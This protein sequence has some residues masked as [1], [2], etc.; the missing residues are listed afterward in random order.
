MPRAWRLVGSS[1]HVGHVCGDDDHY[2]GNHGLEHDDGGDV[3]N[4][5]DDRT[6]LRRDDDG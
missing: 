6:K 4:R 1:G 5:D 2:H 3:D